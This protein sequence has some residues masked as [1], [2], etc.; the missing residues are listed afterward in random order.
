MASFDIVAEPKMAEVTNAVE[1]AKKEITQRYDFKGTKSE[2]TWAD[3]TLTL[4]SNSEEKLKALT[5]VVHEKLIKRGVSLNFFEFG[6]EEPASGQ[7]IRQ[8]ATL[9]KGID[10]EMAK[11]I[12]AAVKDSKLKVQSQIQGE[13]IRVTGKKIDDLQAT[14]QHLKQND[15]GLPLDFINFRS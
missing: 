2:I 1:Q 7:M 10:K 12:N 3:N 11:K 4:L 5:Q 13:Q 15:F 6:K 8:K 14:I 9:K